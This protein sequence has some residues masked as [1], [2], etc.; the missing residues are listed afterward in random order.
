[1]ARHRRTPCASEAAWFATWER[2]GLASFVDRD[3]D[4]VMRVSGDPA[5]NE[6]VL[7]PDAVVLANPEMARLP[8]WVVALVAAGALAAA[9][10]TA[11]GLLL[12]IA[13]AVSHDLLRSMLLP[14]MSDRTELWW[15]RIAAAAAIALAGWFGIHPPGLVAEVVAIAFGIAAS[16][17][18]P[19]I[20][21]GIFWRRATKEG[22]VAAFENSVSPILRARCYECHGTGQSTPF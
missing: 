20:V 11:A 21:M 8:P 17:F 19:A 7:D 16:T 18:F 22:A 13:A 14:R 3:G 4:G 15:A 5:R 9:L 2:T 1:M 6:V 12:V 10:S